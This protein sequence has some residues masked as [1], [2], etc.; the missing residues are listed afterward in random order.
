MPRITAQHLARAIE[1]LRTMTMERKTALADE[2]LKQQPTLFG[3]FLVLTRFSVSFEKM[4]FLLERL[5]VCFLAMRESGIQWP[6]ITEDELDKQA[7]RF[8]A[9]VNFADGL[10]PAL[11]SQ[12]LA[13]YTTGHPEPHLLA[14]VT[15][16]MTQWLAKVKPEESDKYVMLAAMNIVNCIA[17][18][19]LHVASR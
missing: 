15:T 5:F 14:Y 8:S 16:E 2:V 4:E 11:T 10:G 12:S 1:A 9:T 6:R 3:S 19:P 18:V 13:Q 17:H 7:A